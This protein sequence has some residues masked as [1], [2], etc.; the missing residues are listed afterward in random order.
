MKATAASYDEHKIILCGMADL[1]SDHLPQF[2][3]K[4]KCIELQTIK[5]YHSERFQQHALQLFEVL[6]QMMKADHKQKILVQVV[7]PL[8]EKE[9]YD[10]LWAILQTAHLENPHMIGQMIAVETNKSAKE[11]A[12]K[13]KENA[14]SSH[15]D[16]IRYENG[17]RYIANWQVL[18]TTSKSSVL[19]W[20]EGGVY[21]ITGGGMG[22]LGL[23]FAKEIARHTSKS[24][25]ILTGRS[26]Y[27]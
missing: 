12:E 16:N 13:L 8:Q 1:S 10:G 14:L 21:L 6:Q 23:L 7:I 17:K 15:P 19:P 4:G 22:G 18:E 3:E 20:K 2:L 27:G 5:G 26:P 11:V 25:L 9:L 24:T